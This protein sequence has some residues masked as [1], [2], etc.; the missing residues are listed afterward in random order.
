MYFWGR[1]IF[2]GSNVIISEGIFFISKYSFGLYRSWQWQCNM[3]TSE[4]RIF[5]E[6]YV[7]FLPIK[8]PLTTIKATF[9]KS[10]NLSLFIL[11]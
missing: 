2:S 7:R 6:A 5:K 4:E 11:N 8:K 3:L 1:L 10:F 9:F